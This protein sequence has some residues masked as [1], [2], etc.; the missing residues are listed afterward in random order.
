MGFRIYLLKLK[1]SLICQQLSVLQ[2]PFGLRALLF[3]LRAAVLVP[4]LRIRAA[5][6]RTSLTVRLG[7]RTI[8]NP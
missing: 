2:P 7:A 5:P 8:R 4:L 1:E 6:G 3:G